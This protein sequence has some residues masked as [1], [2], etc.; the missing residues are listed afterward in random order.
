MRL[1]WEETSPRGGHER[2]VPVP[3]LELSLN[4]RETVSPEDELA[5]QVED[6]VEPL[7]V[8][9]DRLLHARPGVRLLLHGPADVLLRDQV[10]LNQDLPELRG[11]LLGIQRLGQLV[12]CDLALGHEDLADRLLSR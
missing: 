8:D 1:M 10:L 9:P 12:P 6:A 11:L 7:R 5:H 2:I 4:L 3:P